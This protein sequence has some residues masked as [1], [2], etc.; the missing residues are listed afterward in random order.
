MPVSKTRITA[1]V[2]LFRHLLTA[3][4]LPF[5]TKKVFPEFAYPVLTT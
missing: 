5:T 3:A 2:I 4:E 1:V